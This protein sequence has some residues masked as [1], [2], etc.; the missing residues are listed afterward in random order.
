MEPFWNYI[1]IDQVFGRAIR[2]KSHI[3]D[4]LPKDERNVEQYLNLS[5][6][7]EGDT[8]E[9]VFNVLKKEKWPDLEEIEDDGNIK[10]KLLEKHKTVYKT[11]TKIISMKK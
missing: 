10:M 8:V 2:M 5:S 11:I 9:D 7:P 1:R 3:N 6:L 4:A